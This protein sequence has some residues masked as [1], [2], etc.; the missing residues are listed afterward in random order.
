MA[1]EL[2]PLD[3]VVSSFEDLRSAAQCL[4]QLEVIELLQYFENN[5]ISNI[6]LWNMFGLYSR[7]NN[8]CEGYHNRINSRLQRNHPNIWQLISFMKVE[9]KRVQNIRLQWSS[10]ASNKKKKLTAALQNRHTMGYLIS[11]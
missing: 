11:V 2:M 9:E 7:T 6:E 1:L 10:G 8:T 5:W 3:K 4:P